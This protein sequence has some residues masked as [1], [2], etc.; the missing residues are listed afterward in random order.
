MDFGAVSDPTRLDLSVPPLDPTWAAR[1]PA[2]EGPPRVHTG[3]PLWADKR[4]VGTFYPDDLPQRGWLVHYAARFSAIEHNGTFHALPGATQLAAWKAALPPGFRFCPKVP[5]SISHAGDWRADAPRFGEAVRQLGDHLGPLLF[6]VP[7]EV[8]PEHLP[9]IGARVAALGASLPV[10]VE[11]R[12]PGFFPRGRVL[13]AFAEWIARANLT[14]VVT[15]TP[16]RRDVVHATLPTPRLFLRLRLADHPAIDATRVQAWADRVS[17][18]PGLQEA[19]MFLHTDDVVALLHRLEDLHG[20]LNT[21]LGLTLPTQLTR[22]PAP[23][24]FGPR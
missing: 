3:A 21:R 18:W 9:E 13:P 7:P 24:L 22:P 5:R 10:A 1:W 2:F 4:W 14:A 16:G 15:D 8:G 23:S 11:V 6:Q 19:W 12:H 17:T 20:A